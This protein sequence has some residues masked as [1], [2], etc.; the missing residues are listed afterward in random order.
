M[1]SILS[2]LA[3]IA[4]LSTVVT[5]QKN[6]VELGDVPWLRNYDEAKRVAT[7]QNKPILILFQEVPGCAT[8]RNYGNKVL[9]NP[10]VVDA[11]SN[12]FVP[13]AI[14]NNEGGHDRKVLELYGEPTW[15]NPVVRI[16]D[17]NGK[18]IM[19]RLAGNYSVG[20]LALQM[21]LALN[22]D[23]RQV[24]EYLSLLADASTVQD[25]ETAYYQ[26]YCFWTGEAHFGAK[27]GVVATEPGWMNGAEV[28][29]VT[30]DESA[31]SKNELDSYA[32]SA[33]C[34]PVKA[35]RYRTDKD[36]QYYLKNSKYKYIPLSDIQKSRINSALGQRQDPSV[37][38]SPTQKKW[39]QE[40]ASEKVVYNLPL[41]EAWKMME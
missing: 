33:K 2:I 26:M 19:S 20:G 10:L 31:L 32:K 36:P 38:L 13:L 17:A 18:D 27:D 37:Y 28:V 5:G 16:V 29:K 41:D 30:F 14:F 4:M 25:E 9:S 7:E 6:H 8:C 23:Y 22:R 12:E 21:T 11:I 1:K 34:A 3:M 24:P 15:N 35:G 40:K 39:L